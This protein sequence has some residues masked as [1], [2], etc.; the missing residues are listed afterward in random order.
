MLLLLAQASKHRESDVQKM[1][2]KSFCYG[3]EETSLFE[4]LE[5]KICRFKGFLRRIL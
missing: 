3:I 2:K 5:K 1:W 4:V